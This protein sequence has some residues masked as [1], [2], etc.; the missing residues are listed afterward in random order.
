MNVTNPCNDCIHNMICKYKDS[1]ER[2]SA[3]LSNI[4]AVGIFSVYLRCDYKTATLTAPNLR[5]NTAEDARFLEDRFPPVN[6]KKKKEGGVV[7]RC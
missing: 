5:S 4:D 2:I 3:E 7:N 1:Y 6:T